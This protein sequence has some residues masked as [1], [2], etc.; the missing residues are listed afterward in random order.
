MLAMP[1]GAPGDGDGAMGDGAAGCAD[2]V[3][4][5]VIPVQ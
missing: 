5:Y 4:L 1:N 3:N 2:D